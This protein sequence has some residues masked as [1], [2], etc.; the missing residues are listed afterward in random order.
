M[1]EH[2]LTPWLRDM[3]QRNASDVYIKAYADASRY[4]S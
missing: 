4:S 3:V 1:P 2:N